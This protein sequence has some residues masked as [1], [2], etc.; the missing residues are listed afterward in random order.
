MSFGAVKRENL[1][2]NNDTC[3][4]LLPI[5]SNNKEI[6]KA[7]TVLSNSDNLGLELISKDNNIVYMN[8]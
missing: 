2:L 8:K 5:R 7:I 4:G 3:I 6:S 1:I